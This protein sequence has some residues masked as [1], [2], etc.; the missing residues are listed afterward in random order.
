LRDPFGQTLT[1]TAI[2]PTVI[3]ISHTDKKRDV[4]NPKSRKQEKI[5]L[6]LDFVKYNFF[7]EEPENSKETR[8]FA[9]LT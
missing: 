3:K 9:A 6:K 5:P 8:E 1:S 7:I 4:S 2:S